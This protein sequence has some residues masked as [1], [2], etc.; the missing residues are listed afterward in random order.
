MTRR[1]AVFLSALL[2]AG[3]LVALAPQPAGAVEVCAGEGTAV[4]GAP[5]TYPGLST[6]AQTAFTF[7]F[8]FGACPH[9]PTGTTNKTLTATSWVLGWCGFS[10]GAGITGNG[11]LFAW[12]GLGDFLI[13]T[14]HTVGLVHTTPD[15]LNGESCI[16]GADVFIVTGAVVL[17]NCTSLLGPDIDQ[18][19]GLPN[20]DDFHVFFNSPCVPSGL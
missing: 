8:I 15:V 12:V 7:A 17:S 11:D 4:T 13:L 5:L 3:T 19:T 14:G 20:G 2:A 10:S 18:L 9:I 6:S 1:L 16:T